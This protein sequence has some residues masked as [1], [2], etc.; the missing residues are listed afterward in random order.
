[1][2]S[3][4]WAAERKDV[5][6]VFFGLA[7]LYVY[8]L[9]VEEHKFSKYFLC[10]ILFALGLM[11]KPMLVTLP[12]VLLLL[13]FWP[14]GRWPEVL[15]PPHNPVAV[16]NTASVKKKN[17]HKYNAPQG[18][19]LSVSGKSRSQLIGA[20]L[21]EKAPFVFL[22]IISAVLTIW[23]QSKGGC[24]YCSTKVAVSRTNCKRCHLLYWLFRKDFLAG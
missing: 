24:H 20:L 9:Y 16:N 17:R 23:A 4:A 21:W 3:V 15:N 11:A 12:F 7:A 19:K 5:L 13:D 22:A 8:A 1:M 6:S 14:L 2:E 18:K 10:L